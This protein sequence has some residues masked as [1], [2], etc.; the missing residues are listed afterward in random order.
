MIKRAPALM[1]MALCVCTATAVHAQTTRTWVSGV[2]DD[3]NPCSRTAPCKT[4]AG[5]FAKTQA[6]GEI[7]ALDPSG[8]GALTINKSI[9][10]D[11]G[12]GGVASILVNGTNAILVNAP[13][14]V[15]TLRNLQLQGLAQSGNPGLNGIEVLAAKALHIERCVIQNFGQNGINIASSDGSQVFIL[16]TISRGNLGNG[17]NIAGITNAELVTVSSSHFLNNANGV[18]AGGLTMTTLLGSEAS[19]NSQSGFVV[20]SSNGTA[21]LNLVDSGAINNVRSGLV[22]GGGAAS[23]R[24]RISNVALFGNGAGMTVMSNG[25]IESFKNNLNPGSGA[26]TAFLTPQ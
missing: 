11:G 7:D 15:V 24:I 1:L 12:G 9:T 17:L 25:N 14:A 3:V 4:F 26:P 6:G 20:T 22:A 16:D 13:N 23:V 18:V 21:V 2:G 10:I 19:G 5:A 8:Y